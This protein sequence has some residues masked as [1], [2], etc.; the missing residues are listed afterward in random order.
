MNYHKLILLFK[1][2]YPLASIQWY[3]YEYS[4]EKYEES[5]IL[6]VIY[7][8]L[9]KNSSIIWYFTHNIINMNIKWESR[10]QNHTENLKTVTVTQWNIIDFYIYVRNFLRVIIVKIGLSRL[11]VK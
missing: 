10:V 11:S 1:H 4:N 2:K 9:I 7:L 6:L 8:N 5:N 3:K